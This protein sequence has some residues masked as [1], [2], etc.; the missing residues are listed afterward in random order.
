MGIA[1]ED[2]LLIQALV[3]CCYY[4]I[5][6]I[7]VQDYM[8]LDILRTVHKKRGVLV[9]QPLLDALMMID[10]LHIMHIVL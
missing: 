2:I 10:I 9:I 6:E 8:Q 4:K 3:V 5:V 1:T 7:I